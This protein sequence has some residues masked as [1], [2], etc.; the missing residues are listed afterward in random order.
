MVFDRFSLYIS[1]LEILIWT[2]ISANQSW[3][4]MLERLFSN[5]AHIIITYNVIGP[6]QTAKGP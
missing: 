4:L 3:E 1:V 5:L 2:R 6:G